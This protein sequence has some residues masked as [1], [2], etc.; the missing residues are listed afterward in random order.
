MVGAIIVIVVILLAA[1]FIAPRARA[2]GK[3][4]RERRK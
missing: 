4:V 1:V 3:S 2:Y